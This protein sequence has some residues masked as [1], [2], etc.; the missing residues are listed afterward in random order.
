M[1][2]PST[3]DDVGNYIEDTQPL[4]IAYD[5]DEGE[6]PSEAV[7]RAT[8]ALT[9][10][11]VVDLDPLFDVVDPEHLD[12]LVGAPDPS[13]THKAS[14]VTFTFNGCHVSVSGQQIVVRRT[15]VVP[16]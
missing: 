8:A 5:I 12:G 14:S 10:R 4:E 15:D 13:P 11:S 6:R 7:V 2:D 3:P 9:D 16:D 1:T